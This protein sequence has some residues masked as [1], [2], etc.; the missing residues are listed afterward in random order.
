MNLVSPKPVALMSVP[1]NA[2][3]VSQDQAK[4]N[5]LVR[6]QKPVYEDSIYLFYR[7]I[8]MNEPVLEFAAANDGKY[9]VRATIVPTFDPRQD[10]FVPKWAY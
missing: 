1:E 9:A 10:F 7:N 5:I 8:D 4:K 3:I 2:E 6:L